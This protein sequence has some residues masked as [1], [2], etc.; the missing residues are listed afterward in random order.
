MGQKRRYEAKISLT[1]TEWEKMS[2]PKLKDKELKEKR[3]YIKGIEKK[4]LD[5]VKDLGDQF[6][7]DSF[8]IL[9]L[10]SESK[11]VRNK[12]DVYAAFEAY[13]SKLREEGRIGTEKS[14]EAALK[15]L[16]QFISKL[17]F[18]DI[19]VPFLEAYEGY[20]LK[21]GKSVTTIGI[22]LRSLRTIVNIARSEKVINEERYPFGLKSRKKYEI[23]RANNIKKALDES[24]LTKI[25]VGECQNDE[26]AWA[27][28]MWLFSFYCNGM[29]MADIFH[30]KYGNMKGEFLYFVRQKTIRTKKVQEPIEIYLSEPIREII[31]KWGTLDKSADNYVFGVFNNRMTPE[32]IYRIRLNTIRSINHYMKNIGKRLKIDVPITTYVARHSWATTLL[33]KGIST[34]YISKGFGHASFS[35]TEQYLGGFTQDQKKSVADLLTNLANG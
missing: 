23:P 8:D 25:L 27:R 11:L 2:A 20:M 26:E 10:G 12:Q 15:S 31:E 17:N 24:A 7:M 21:Q 6:T 28:D 9:F 33:R 3:V 34:A 30:L 14:Y 16:R 4:A 5:I 18:S 22:Y 1:E 29:N 19:T 13:I 35:T 32:E